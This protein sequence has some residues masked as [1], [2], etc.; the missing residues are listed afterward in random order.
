MS[1]DDIEVSIVFPCL[2][3]ENT[4]GPCVQIALRTLADNATAGEVIV[5]DNGSTDRTREIALA[6]GA[7]IFDVPQQGYGNALRLG[8]KHARGRFIVF[9]DADLS[10]DV[11]EAP[12]FIERLREGADLVIGSRFRGGIDP[13]AMPWLHRVLGTPFLTTV[14]NLMFGCGI[15]DINCGMRALT[16][17]AFDRLALNSEGMEFASEMMVKAARARM[18]IDEVPI[19]FHADQRGRRPHLRSF[20]DGWRHLQLMMHFCPIWIFLL[21]GLILS[22]GGLAMI[23]SSLNPPAGLLTYLAAL[24][25]TTLGIQILLLAVATQSRVKSA[26]FAQWRD[27]WLYRVLTNV[28]RLEKGLVLGLIVALIGAGL[29]AD[30]AWRTTQASYPEGYIS[31]QFDAAAAKL[32]LLGASLFINGLQVLFTS[33]FLGLFGIRVADD[34]PQWPKE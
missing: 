9:L 28:I 19:H 22:L 27:T 23:L 13:G 30:A 10:Y 20:R 24:C 16:R 6:E 2:N 34:E 32:A 4:V 12:G 25:C 5:A 18:R 1:A 11:T 15:S 31:I 7:R 14:A 17:D 29:F 8:M 3:E 26:K 33:L 21:P